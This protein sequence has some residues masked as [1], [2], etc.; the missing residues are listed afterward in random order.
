MAEWPRLHRLP[1]EYTQEELGRLLDYL[2]E[3]ASPPDWPAKLAEALRARRAN[4]RLLL[5]WLDARWEQ[6]PASK[7]P[8]RIPTRRA[9]I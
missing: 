1:L 2:K 4:E 7:L 9:S 8:R 3:A 5:T 6:L